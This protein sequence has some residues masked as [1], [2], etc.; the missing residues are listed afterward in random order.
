MPLPG[1]TE[2]VPNLSTA[3]GLTRIR[4]LGKQQKTNKTKKLLVPTLVYHLLPWNA[5]KFVFCLSGL[6]FCRLVEYRET[7]SDACCHIRLHARTAEL[8]L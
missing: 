7:L 5:H 4:A 1:L 2:E 3:P 8:L 6:S